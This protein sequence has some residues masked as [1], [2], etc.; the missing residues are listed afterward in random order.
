MTE[1]QYTPEQISLF[2]QLEA[3]AAAMEMHIKRSEALALEATRVQRELEDTEPG[4]KV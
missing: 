4:T 1:P 3:I 2:A